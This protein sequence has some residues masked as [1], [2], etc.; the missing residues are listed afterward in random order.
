[1]IERFG[2]DGEVREALSS[3]PNIPVSLRADLVV[4]TA[5]SLRA[6]VTEREWMSSE[7][8]KRATREACEQAHVII[9]A[10]SGEGED[11][12]AKLI[13]HLRA[14]SQL[15]AGLLLRALLSGNSS[16]L[17]AALAELSDVPSRVLKA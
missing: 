3:R 5:D 16:L 10:T 8:A 11:G 13:A 17:E 9:A 14:S 15:T 1:M 7:R 12:T 4:A 2:F 6:F